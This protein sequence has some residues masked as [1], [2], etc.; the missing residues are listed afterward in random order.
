M[1]KEIFI[2]V[3]CKIFLSF[4]TENQIDVFC[5]KDNFIRNEPFIL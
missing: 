4:F 2:S 5:Y 3:D 1:K